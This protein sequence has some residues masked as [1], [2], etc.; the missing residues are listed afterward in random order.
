MEIMGRLKEQGESLILASHDPIVCE[1]K[2]AKRVIGICDGQGVSAG[3]RELPANNLSVDFP[4]FT[5]LMV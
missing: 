3:G 4:F 1:S 2:P 5:D